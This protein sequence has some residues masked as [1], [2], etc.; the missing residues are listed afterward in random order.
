M[1]INFESRRKFFYI[2]SGEMRRKESFG[3]DFVE[4]LDLE[5]A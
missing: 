2:E 1:Y 5:F 4:S 3:D